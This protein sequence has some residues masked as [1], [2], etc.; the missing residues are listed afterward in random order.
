MGEEFW[1]LARGTAEE[2]GLLKRLPSCYNMREELKSVERMGLVAICK[3]SR[4]P[5]KYTEGSFKA[6]RTD[7]GIPD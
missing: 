2:L 5:T 4:Q 3:S 1:H 6:H 7:L